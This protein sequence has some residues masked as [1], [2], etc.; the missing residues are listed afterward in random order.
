VPLY[1]A[2]VGVRLDLVHHFD[3]AY[4]VLFLGFACAV[5]A[6]SIYVGA[7]AAGES[8]ASAVNFAAALN[9]RG[10]PGIVLAAVAYEATIINENF[11]AILVLTAIVTSM[12]AG[13]WL[14]RA[15]RHGLPLRED[16]QSHLRGA[17]A[18]AQA[19][20]AQPTVR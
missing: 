9:A 20:G 2:L 12:A 11:F 13:S 16:R 5:K 1:F 7:R 6:A 18:T 17:V 4:F 3:V 14:G 15:V 19:A 10:G 8:A